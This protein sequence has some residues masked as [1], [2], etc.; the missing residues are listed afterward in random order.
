MNNIA[1]KTARVKTAPQIGTEI[2][3]SRQARRK[4]Y[5]VPALAEYTPSTALTDAGNATRLLERHGASMHYVPA[6]NSWMV[7]NGSKW[8]KDENGSAWLFAE[9][10]LRRLYTSAGETDDGNER[11][12]LAKFAL[13]CELERKLKSM[14]AIAQHRPGI[15]VSVEELDANQMIFNCTNGTINLT[16][17]TFK[18]NDP[19]DLC[20]KQTGVEYTPRAEC[21]TWTG[22]LNKI[23]DG[24]QALISFMQ[25]AIGYALTGLT[26]EQSL[27]ILYGN[28]SNG[29]STLIDV[30]MKLL[31]E[32]AINTPA[33][34]LLAK[35][36]MPQPTM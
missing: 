36:A 35:K 30:L 2:S 24:N 14:L 1:R 7:W 8:E 13:A 6:W 21:L 34:T 23:F 26:I 3:T 17:G 11:K 12:A 4:L 25:R 19:D 5:L 28:G 16:L 31:G 18:A 10:T 20:T 27:F 29:K 9:D 32:Y 33:S 22:F 15:P